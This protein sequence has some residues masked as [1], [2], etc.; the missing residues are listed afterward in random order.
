MALLDA[1]IDRVAAGEYESIVFSSVNGVNAYCDRLWS[2]GG[3]ARCLA[4][5]RIAAIGPATAAALQRY[6][7][8]A[9]LRPEVFRAESLAEVLIP[10]SRGKSVLLVRASRGR[11][12][13]A[14]MLAAADAQVHQVVAYES[15]DATHVTELLRRRL[16]DGTVD[17][18]SGHKFGHRTV[19][20]P[21]AWRSARPDT[22]D[23]H[24]PS[25]LGDPA[26]VRSCAASGGGDLHSR[27]DARPI[28]RRRRRFINVGRSGVVPYRAV[29]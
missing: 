1:A 22:C 8:R 26:R 15:R 12:V 19:A 13:L 25:N 7:L 28:N 23:E 14:E 5:T 4:T 20:P 11:E 9:D 16:R 27:W 24:Q 29:R 2:R 3:D 6:S 17:W 21:N 10:H 18:T